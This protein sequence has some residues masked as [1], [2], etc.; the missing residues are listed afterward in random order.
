MFGGPSR[1]W[2]GILLNI[3]LIVHYVFSIGIEVGNDSTYKSFG[4]GAQSFVTYF[5]FKICFEVSP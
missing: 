5:K 3:G 4:A 1:Q 2:L